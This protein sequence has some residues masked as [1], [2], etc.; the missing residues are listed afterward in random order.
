MSTPD[1][2]LAIEAPA[3]HRRGYPLLVAV[4]VR[5]A[6]PQRTYFALP[7]I[8]RFEVPPPVE[9]VVTPPGA[10]EGEIL[11]SRPE[12]TGEDEPK[13][14]RLGGGEA[15]RMLFDLSELH[16]DLV[17]GA[18][19]LDARYLGPV[20][21]IAAPVTFEVEVPGAQEAEAVAGLRAS[22]RTH[23]PSWTAFLTDNFREVAADELVGIPAAGRERLAFTLALHRAIHGPLGVAQL[24]P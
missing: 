8:D 4:T 2:E 23:E 15:R 20:G 22:N 5:N 12:G 7:A 19:R 10:S 17:A 11:P 6:L 18:H 14:M 13:G 21:A 9:F 16:P 24:D 1:L 3:I